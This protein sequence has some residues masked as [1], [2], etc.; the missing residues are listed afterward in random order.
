MRLLLAL[1]ALSLSG[2]AQAQ[3]ITEEATRQ[4]ALRTVAR[5]GAC[6]VGGHRSQVV[7]IM[8]AA[9]GSEREA[10]LV[11]ELANVGGVCLTRASRSAADQVRLAIQP[12]TWRGPLAEALYRR[13]FIA[14][15]HPRPFAREFASL[16]D[17]VA[18]AGDAA[19]PTQVLGGVLL[20]A[21]AH[22]VVEAAPADALALIDTLAASPQER[23]AIDRLSPRFGPCFPGGRTMRIN[24]PMLRG[25]I[26]EAVYR[27]S[28]A[29]VQAR[30]QPGGGAR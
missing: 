17:L 5:F 25:F 2:A 14:L 16:P 24:R 4:E 29:L 18:L 1:C 8:E 12:A 20:G 9:P 26:A 13:D 21:F 3:T 30:A 27:Y 19:V 7:Q 22:C 6:L 23:A 15:G 10:G 28:V 11:R